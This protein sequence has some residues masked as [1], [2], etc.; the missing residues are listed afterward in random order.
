M[1]PP[2]IYRLIQ[3]IT[4]LNET[5]I[6]KG[7][8]DVYLRINKYVNWRVYN[9]CKVVYVDKSVDPLGPFSYFTVT[10]KLQK[11]VGIDYR[12]DGMADNKDNN[13]K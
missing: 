8:I 7:I 3:Q 2:K 11:L 5:P 9:K 6:I 12:S 1:V 4:I 10:C 13:C